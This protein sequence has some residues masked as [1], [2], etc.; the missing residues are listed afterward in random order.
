M[1]ISVIVATYN[2]ARLLDE[3]LRHIARQRFETGDE[4]IVVDNGSTDDTSAVLAAHQRISPAP[5]HIR[6]EPEPGKSRAL[7]RA[8]GGARGDVLAF[9]DDDVNV[10]DG[11]L[12]AIREAMRDG[13][14]ALVGGRVGPRW[15]RQPPRWLRP[16]TDGYGRL[17]APLAL[18]DYGPQPAALGAR[19]A[20][21]AN[22]AVRREVVEQVGGFAPHLGK[23]RGTLLSGEDHELCQRIQAAGWSTAYWP[24]ARVSHWVPAERTRLRYFVAWF[25]WSGITHAALEGDGPPRGRTVLGVPA[26][27]VRRFFGG[28]AG[29]CAACGLG[30]LASARERLVDAAFAAGY[31]AAR[32]RLVTVADARPMRHA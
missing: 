3:C 2:R 1:T 18:L 4:I 7:A 19:T 5:L 10:D 21:G 25:F 6:V 22:L 16:G 11:W 27:L 30:R 32:W 31:A 20:L 17:A 23:L 24:A 12:D 13:R 29:A 15:Q 26:Y 28:L 14:L 8:I 9:T